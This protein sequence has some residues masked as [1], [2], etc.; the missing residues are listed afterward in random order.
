[1]VIVPPVSEYP[2]AFNVPPESN[3]PV[4]TTAPA[5]CVVVPRSSVPALSESEPPEGRALSMVALKSPPLTSVPPVYKFTALSVTE[6]VPDF[7]SFAA[8]LK[9]DPAV[10]FWKLKRFAEVI[11]PPEMTPPVRTT[12]E[13]VC[14]ELPKLS[15]PPLTVTEP[16][17][18]SVPLIP[19]AS[20]PLVIVVEP[21]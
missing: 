5:V 21:V 7:A 9:T 16:A 2:V 4:S 17:E 1:M 15:E 12:F 8:P 3:P 11:V 19:R 6:P 14:E 10:P 20:V 13:R 18:P